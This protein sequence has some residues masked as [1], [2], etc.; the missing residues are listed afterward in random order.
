MK[1]YFFISVVVVL[2]NLLLS[3]IVPCILKDSDQPFVENV[4]KVFNNNKQLI[5]T[6]SIIL[7]VI[8]YT[9]LCIAP[10]VDDTLTNLT[11]YSFSD[12]AP[13]ITPRNVINMRNFLQL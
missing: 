8:V 2:L 13:D 7:G 9:A 4:K 6:N 3:L 1:L 5:I 10:S 11:G 12:E